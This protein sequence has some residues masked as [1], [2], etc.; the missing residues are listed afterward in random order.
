[1]ELLWVTEL[2]SGVRRHVSYN[3]IPPGV[4]IFCGLR[5]EGERGA[6][7]SGEEMRG[8]RAHDEGAKRREGERRPGLESRPALGQGRAWRPFNSE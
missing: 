7:G 5:G 6:A 8:R 4:N 2:V 1:M 3:V